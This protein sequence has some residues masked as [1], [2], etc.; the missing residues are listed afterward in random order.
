[1]EKL[2]T[3]VNGVSR[4]YTEAEYAQAAID[5]Q[6]ILTGLPNTIRK[7]RDNLLAKCDWTQVNDSP[8]STEQKTAWATYRQALRNVPTQS[9]FPTN[10]TWP[11]EPK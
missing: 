1:M 3:L 9:G 5:A 11:T 6:S 7:E 4:E 8:L 2:Y 10:V